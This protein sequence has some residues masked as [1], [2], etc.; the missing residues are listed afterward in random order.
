MIYNIIS[1]ESTS[2]GF[3]V[4]F[5]FEEMKYLIYSFLHSSNEAKRSVEFCQHN[6]KVRNGSVFTLGFLC[7]P[8]PCVVYR[9]YN[10]L[11]SL[12]YLVLITY[13]TYC[14]Y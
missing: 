14:K 9:F 3:K 8:M 5:P 4:G 10:I 1:F 2:C 11:S 13:G 7:L 6:V 12:S